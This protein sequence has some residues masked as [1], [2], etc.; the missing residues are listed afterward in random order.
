MPPASDRPIL[1]LRKPPVHRLSLNELLERGTLTSK[2][3]QFLR[4]EVRRVASENVFPRIA[5][6]PHDNATQG[7]LEYNP[8]SVLA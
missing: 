1:A 7:S 8:P 3:A 6:L 2:Q 4:V 5:S